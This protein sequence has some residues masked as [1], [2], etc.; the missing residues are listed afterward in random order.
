MKSP[1]ALTS[2]LFLALISIAQLI[3]FLLGVEI[4]ING[5]TIPVFLSLPAFVSA[6][7][8]AAWLWME[9]KNSAA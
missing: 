7:T 8:L 5:Y 9:R 3:R 4:L 6:A 1:A 2:S